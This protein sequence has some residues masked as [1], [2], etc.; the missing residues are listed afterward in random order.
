MFAD[1]SG[2]ILYLQ[3]GLFE[4]WELLPTELEHVF[5]GAPAPSDW[6][7]YLQLIAFGWSEQG[8]QQFDLCLASF[9]VSDPTMFIR[10]L[11]MSDAPDPPNP[12]DCSS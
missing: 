6:P 7:L 9:D 11:Q 2:S 12:N 1:E 3:Y 8:L 4:P 10:G 5:V